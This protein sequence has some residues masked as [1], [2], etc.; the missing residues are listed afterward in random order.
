[1]SDIESRKTPRLVS[2]AKSPRETVYALTELAEAKLNWPMDKLLF[3]SFLAGCY[4]SLGGFFAMSISRGFIG[5]SPGLVKLLQGATFP[6][7]LVLIIVFSGCELFTGNCMYYFLSC[8]N[9]H[10][11][12]KS[13]IFGLVISYI[14]NY[15]G[16]QLCVFLFGYVTEL[17][18]VDPW[19]TGVTAYA[20]VKVSQNFGIIL[21]KVLLCFNAAFFLLHLT[22]PSLLPSFI[23]GHSRQLP[24]VCSHLLRN[25]VRGLEW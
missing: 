4:I 8:A 19:L 12:I 2:A 22:F 25:D 9:K 14:G 17:Y 10:V 7:G 15:M 11:S 21:L 5:A 3:M 18:S 13:G 23:S 20:D 1:M 24:S 6:L 16:T